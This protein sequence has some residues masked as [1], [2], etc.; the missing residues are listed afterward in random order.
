MRLIK[1][2]LSP[3]AQHRGAPPCLQYIL[4]TDNLEKV[5]NTAACRAGTSAAACGPG[6]F[7][8]AF[9]AGPAGGGMP[10]IFSQ[11]PDELG[12][13]ANS[14]QQSGGRGLA[15]Q[16]STHGSL[17]DRVVHGVFQGQLGAWLQATVEPVPQVLLHMFCTCPADS[18]VL[19]C[20]LHTMYRRA[21]AHT[22]EHYHFCHAG[23]APLLRW[24]LLPAGA[25]LHDALSPGC[26]LPQVTY[27]A[28]FSVTSKTR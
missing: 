17:A 23:A 15:A 25:D 3:A 8:A 20:Y 11:P 28:A 21:V 4:R 19:C 2:A 1:S 12:S 18:L 13:T 22:L 7:N 9:P 6:F 14:G 24:L 26:L 5:P 16:L 27:S 10:L